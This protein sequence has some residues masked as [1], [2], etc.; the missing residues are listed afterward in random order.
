MKPKTIIV[1]FR[2]GECV[3][4]YIQNRKYLNNFIK[5]NFK[6]RV[7]PKYKNVDKTDRNFKI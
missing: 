2:A 5:S 1:I 7:I 4:N 3:W 6:H